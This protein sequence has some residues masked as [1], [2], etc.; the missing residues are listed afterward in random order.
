[1]IKKTFGALL[2]SIILLT[3][4]TNILDKK[5]NS[6]DFE[7]VKETINADETLSAKKKAYIIDNMSMVLGFAQLGK[8]LNIDASNAPTFKEEIED[9]S[10]EYDSILNTKLLI[11][12]NNKKLE[13]LI[14]L[15]GASVVSIDKY[16]GYLTMNLKFNNQFEKE[17]LYLI[18]NYKY[19]NEYDTEFFDEKSKLTDEVAKDF[20]G[21]L[22]ISTKE[23]YNDVA[24]FI[25]TKVPV[26]EKPQSEFLMAGLKVETLGIVFKDK[27][28]VFPQDEEWEYFDE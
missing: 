5:V 28:E 20:K 1:M 12:E 14:E 25:Y 24:E 18:L 27:S 21:E 23:E 26:K 15:I 8:A 9:Y 13:E 10:L 17:I 7:K 6:K 2:L 4:C 19:V 11:K 22:E 16:K 3:G